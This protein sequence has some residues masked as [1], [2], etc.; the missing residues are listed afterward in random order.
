M[1][2]LS[3]VWCGSI[4]RSTRVFVGIRCVCFGSIPVLVVRVA[5]LSVGTSTF[6]TRMV[7]MFFVTEAWDWLTA[8]FH[9][10][11]FLCLHLFSFLR[12]IFSDSE[13]PLSRDDGGVRFL[14]S[15]SDLM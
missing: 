11:G 2:V 9:V 10:Q 8:G 3:V 13:C 4:R 5:F 1:F 15:S 6:V 12:D 7:D 14:A